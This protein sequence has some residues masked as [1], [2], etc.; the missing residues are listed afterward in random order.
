M[1]TLPRT[2]GR[3]LLALGWGLCGCDAKPAAKSA[4]AGAAANNPLTA[5]VDYLG[6]QGRAKQHA[7]RMI[8]TVEIE[9]AIRQFQGIEDRLPTGFEELV[10]QH[11]LPA[12]PAAPRGRRFVYNP[13]TGQVGLVAE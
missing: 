6:A 10:A 2:A 9:S 13:Q 1:N 5:P 11:Y 7:T 3:L 4:P 8:S 12:L